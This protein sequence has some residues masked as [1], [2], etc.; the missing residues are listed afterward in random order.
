MKT[1]TLYYATNRNHLGSNQWEPDGYGTEFSKSKGAKLQNLRFGKLTVEAEEKEMDDYLNQQVDGSEGYGA[2][3]SACLTKIAD[4][5][6]IR[7]YKEDL[8]NADN[9]KNRYGSSEMFNELKTKTAKGADILIYIHGFNNDWHDSV[10]SALAL[11]EMVNKKTSGKQDEIVVVLFSWPSNGRIYPLVS[12]Y[13]TRDDASNIAGAKSFARGML[14]LRDCLLSIETARQCQ[15]KI[16]LLCHSM[17]NYVLQHSLESMI[18]F[19]SGKLP[20]LFDHIFMCAADVDND[21]FEPG[22]SMES[23]PKLARRISIYH[24]EQD[25]TLWVS[26]KTKGNPDRLGRDGVASF[27]SLPRKIHQIDCT[28]VVKKGITEHSY[29]L[30]GLVNQDIR[31]SLS[32]F[33][34]NHEVR[35]RTG[36]KQANHWKLEEKSEEKPD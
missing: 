18:N 12:Y 23:L 7:A 31:L 2:K 30:N 32:G 5:A 11:Q 9:T 20:L 19:A 29:H 14:K 1:L 21:V 4:T 13:D 36:Q 26:D 34:A 3:L 8:S 25:L 10:G 27:G 15:C 6:K 24:N 33:N 35:N 16:H 28:A 17:G 22:K